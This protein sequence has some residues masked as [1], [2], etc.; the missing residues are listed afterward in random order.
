M[1]AFLRSALAFSGGVLYLGFG[2]GSVF[3]DRNKFN[4][5]RER[6]AVARACV[7][8]CLLS[9]FRLGLEFLDDLLAIRHSPLLCD[10]GWCCLGRYFSILL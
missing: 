10:R 2:F 5:A 1:V 7:V 9:A 3:L 8:F 6:G 4:P